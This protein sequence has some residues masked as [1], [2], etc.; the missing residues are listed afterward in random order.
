[1]AAFVKFSRGLI[2]Q[3]N[4]LRDN[5]KLDN[6]T[7]YLVYEDTNSTTGQLYL[8]NKLISS[9]NISS[10]NLSDISDINIPEELE[11]GMLLQY[12]QSTVPGESGRWEARPIA[13]VLSHYEG[14]GGSS[15]IPVVDNLN[16]IENP[17][18]NDIAIQGTELFIYDGTQWQPLTV[19]DLKNRVSELERKVGVEGNTESG[20]VAT[21][22]Y[23]KLN[24]LRDELN[25]QIDSKIADAQ[26]LR[27]QVVSSLDDIHLDNKEE[28]KNTVFLVPKNDASADDGYD[29]YLVND[30]KLER[31]GSWT[32]NLTGY[33]KNDDDRLLDS[34]QK[35]KL[36]S[37]GLNDN[38]QAIIT[39]S[40]V[41]DLSQFIE[42]NSKIKTVQSGVLDI[43]PEG[44]LQL[45]GIPTTVLNETV[46]PLIQSAIGDL[47]I[48]G[49][50]RY[51]DDST[52]AEEIKHIKESIVWQELE[53]QALT[54]G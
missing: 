11:D 40:Q 41:S 13:D 38:N 18:E 7:L 15:N 21:G 49:D 47:S 33:V 54:Q 25:T 30:G 34:E 16:N 51:S 19:S 22:L 35:Q 53:K 50:N 31:L 24:N 39:A 26:H 9:T 44:E 1:M 43:T 29:E 6:D 20:Q 46:S 48:L 10:I 14:S 28:T 45:V 37:I 42:N 52:V 8:G 27:Y 17:S 3:Y 23:E 32:G 4:A 12:N 2:N 36:D 5:N